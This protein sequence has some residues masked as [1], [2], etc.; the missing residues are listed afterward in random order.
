MLIIILEKEGLFKTY[1]WHTNVDPIDPYTVDIHLYVV[2]HICMSTVYG[3]IRFLQ[4]FLLVL[5]AQQNRQCWCGFNQILAEV[6][7]Q[8][9]STAKSCFALRKTTSAIL[10]TFNGALSVHPSIHLS[11]CF[12]RLLQDRVAT[13]V[14]SFQQQRAASSGCL[15]SSP[16]LKD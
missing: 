6:E 3:S 8:T 2:I 16:C 15:S 12:L 4:Y 10:C 11:I 13:S 9:R 1:S 14:G 7:L 5:N